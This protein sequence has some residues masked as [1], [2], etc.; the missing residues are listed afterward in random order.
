MNKYVT[1]KHAPAYTIRLYS[2][3]HTDNMTHYS[4]QILEETQNHT[5]TKIIQTL[6]SY[7]QS[8]AGLKMRTRYWHHKLVDSLSNMERIA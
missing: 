3:V 1:N 5:G 6:K 7:R 2:A 8:R 4:V